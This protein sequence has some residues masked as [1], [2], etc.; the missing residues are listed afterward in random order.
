MKVVTGQII[1]STSGSST[2]LPALTKCTVAVR[3]PG[4]W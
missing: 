1:A 4:S 3:T 2:S